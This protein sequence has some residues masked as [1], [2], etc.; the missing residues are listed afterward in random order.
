M[1]D[2]EGEFL[3]FLSLPQELQDA[4]TADYC[5]VCGQPKGPDCEA[6]EFYADPAHR[7]PVGPPRR[8]LHGSTRIEL[9]ADQL[10]HPVKVDYEAD[11]AYIEVVPRP[12]PAGCVVC[13]DTTYKD[14]GVLVDY[15]ADGA[16]LGIEIFLRHAAV[17]AET[18]A[19]LRELLPGAL[20][21]QET[22]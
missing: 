19:V 17:R 2:D 1:S 14:D 18:V 4:V 10:G 3:G 9:I 8:R 7:E 12:R 15:D 16:M 5:G 11:M 13:T 21:E 20:G 22:P 6:A